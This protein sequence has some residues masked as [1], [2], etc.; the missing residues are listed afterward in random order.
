MSGAAQRP[1]VEAVLAGLKDFQRTTVDH[2]Y[3][4][5]YKDADQTRRYLIA[6]EVGLGKTLI[7]RGVIARTIDELWDKVDRI[8]IV[9]IC[10]NAEI[11]RQNINRL[12]IDPDRNVTLA[13][14]ITMLP[15]QV[16]E[17]QG[18]KLNF[19]SFT[20]G[21]SF[22]LKSSMGMAEERALLYWLLKSTR[23]VLPAGAIR[24][25]QGTAQLPR[26][27]VRLKNFRRDHKI[28]RSLRLAFRKA[29]RHHCQ[30][31]REAGQPDLMYR[32]K[33]TCRALRGH[34]G[35]I[36]REIKNDRSRIIGELRT[37]L[38]ATC[39]RALE[40][41]LIILDE[42]QRF[43]HLLSDEDDAGALAHELFSYQDETSESRVILLSATPYKMYTVA[44]EDEGDDHYRD[45]LD[46]LKFLAGG[47]DEVQRIEAMLRDYRGEM[48][49]LTKG[50]GARL[51]EIRCAL[52]RTLAR[53]MTRRE[54]LAVTEDR[55]G[56]LFER[57][58]PDMRFEP[59][60]ARGYVGLMRL[61]RELDHDD[62]LEYWKA[63]PYL[64]GFMDGYKLKTRF[65]EKLD[66]PAHEQA[67]AALIR[68]DAGL[69]LPWADVLK[70]Q[71][72]DPGNARMRW[73]VDEIV[74][75]G[76]WRLMW[77]PASLPYTA[78]EGDFA[79]CNAFTKRLIFS[80][81][82]VAPKAIAA[83]VSYEAERRM[84]TGRDPK[85]VNTPEDRA[86]RSGLLR[87]S[88]SEGRETGMPMLAMMYPSVALARA[89]DPL[90]Y[91]AGSGDPPARADVLR[92]I[93]EQLQPLLAPLL[94]K[95]SPEGAVDE[96]WYWAA[97]ILLDQAVDA[98]ATQDWWSRGDLAATWATAPD[99]DDQD[100][101]REDIGWAQ[102]VA[103]AKGVLE[104]EHALG[105][106]PDDLPDVLA[107]MALSGPGVVALRA[108]GRVA[109]GP[110]AWREHWL[111]RDAARVA[112]G[113]RSLFNLPETMGLLRGD[114]DELPYWR[115]VLEYCAAGD[116]QAVLDEFAHVLFELQGLPG[117]SNERVSLEV[118]D[119]MAQALSIRTTRLGVDDIRVG[120]NGDRVRL[121]SRNMRARFAIRFGEESDDEG[122]ARTR[123]AHARAAFNSPFWPFVLASTSVG[124]EG[125]DFHPYCHAVVHWNLPSNPV[126][127]E[128]REG[129]VHRYK[130]HAVRRNV[131]RQHRTEA[132]SNPGGDPWAVLF[133]LAAAA[134]EAGQSDLVPFW[135]YPVANGARIERH[136]PALPLSRE[137]ARLEA[138]R[139][140]LAVYRMV[141]G[142]P[143]QDDLVQYLKQHMT[144]EEV[145]THVR[146]FQ[147]DLTPERA[148]AA[149][150]IE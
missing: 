93:R 86:R 107:L 122:M 132:L 38:A 52:E 17:L 145:M 134:R 8:D 15:V 119:A 83:L 12:N 138:L 21:T 7:A 104:G 54:R 127:L 87:F 108:L 130:G 92:A 67:L 44:R 147:V 94:E 48:F 70:Y 22:A 142:Q 100:G 120:R 61:A 42:F 112:A 146:E 62:P 133:G 19:I 37:I 43:K 30:V 144:V 13:S 80:A 139:R 102:H 47:D 89:G 36:P 65:K 58:A 140:S 96:A 78:P 68:Q 109:G 79:A 69:L 123:A 85:A 6:D 114:G 34:K 105:P 150:G 77:I 74:N 128:Q 125:L 124:Q 57:P 31:Q 63:A 50:G 35:K 39:V 95:A 32:F 23:K 106:V 115:E 59:R 73:L 97:P 29:L 1:N 55:N 137:E 84:I 5:L 103:R 118:A 53:F 149:E 72:I 64:L 41:D 18:N 110:E 88:V 9:Y 4:R 24:L 113:F 51:E 2:V 20:P 117:S 56:M 136:V 90:R 111:R 49:A 27:R 131:A 40:P 75:T 14:R 66:D 33:R 101:A 81:W 121:K 26:F 11:A 46:T 10:S 3:R 143:R 116:L 82:R 45:F 16:K 60:D 76:A 91:V 99:V 25:L 71:E 126:D 141:F 129:R 28:D 98:A 148:R 135:L